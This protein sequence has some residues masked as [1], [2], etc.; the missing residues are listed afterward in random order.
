[1]GVLCGRSASALVGYAA[2]P[3]LLLSYYIIFVFTCQ[4][5]MQNFFKIFCNCPVSPVQIV[6]GVV[7]TRGGLRRAQQAGVS[8]LTTLEK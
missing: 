1:M 8:A 2:R 5:F 3:F 6:P 7:C 4:E